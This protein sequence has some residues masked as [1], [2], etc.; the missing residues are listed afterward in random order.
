MES[1]ITANPLIRAQEQEEVLAVAPAVVEEAVEALP[2][3][4]Q[5][6]VVVDSEA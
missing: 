3:A 2:V 4:E 6:Q 5:D 1:Y